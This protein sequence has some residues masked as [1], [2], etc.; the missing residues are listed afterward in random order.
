MS[1]RGVIVALVLGCVGG[2]VSPPEPDPY[3]AHT[4]HN[5]ELAAASYETGA[6]TTLP[7]EERL[8]GSHPVDFY[9]QLALERNPEILATQRAV[10]AQAEVIPQVTALEDPML[11]D[12]FQPILGNSLQT[13]SG[14][15][16][17]QLTISQKYPWFGKLRVRGEV[18]EQ[19]AKIALTQLAQTQLKVIEEVKAAYYAVY[20]NEE[21][22]QIT[23]SSKKPL[24][25]LVQLADAKNRAGG[26]Q[27]DVLRA[28][29]E[30]YRLQ[31][32]L[33]Q[34]ERQLRVA[35]ADLAEL[36]HAS[37]DIEPRTAEPLDLPSAPAEID[38]LY[39]AAV[40]CRPELQERLHAIV[41]D[42]RRQELANLQYYPD[43]TLG[44]GWQAVTKD[45]ALS[46]RANGHDN[47]AFTVGINLPIWQDKLRA[48]VR[49]AE[50]RTVQSARHY[51]ATRDETFRLIRRL[52]AQ[53]DALQQQIEL[54]QGNIIPTARQT[55]DT[56]IGEYRVDKVDFEQIIDNW[57][58]LLE[59]QI[60]LARLET[61]L[62]QVLASLERVVG[63]QLASLPQTE[64]ETEL[65]PPPLPVPEDEG[66]AVPDEN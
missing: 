65:A 59:L 33:I 66:T 18:A 58:A 2:C 41:R 27:Q 32:R 6:P 64:P 53:A 23:L 16:P 25:D 35:Q 4:V 30:L 55:L 10:A 36:L 24:E 7:R 37:P 12:S 56:S 19:E 14:R 63:C 13:A 61:T 38:L 50:H 49:E 1:H 17:N 34:L 60:Q 9:V 52:I 42:Q 48:G 29:L 31:D 43:V 62:G 39:D 57:T 20:F 45:D 46:L 15:I 21:A 51:D 5:I 26:S 11:V 8:D 47:V 44:A 3:Y 40:R 22:I 54:F 28:E